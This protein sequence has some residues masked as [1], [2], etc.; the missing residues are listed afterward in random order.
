VTGTLTYAGK[1]VE[2]TGRGYHDHQWCNINPMVAWRHWL[3]GRMY[4]EQYTIYIYDFVASERFGFTPVPFFGVQDNHTSETIFHTDGN[5]T[6]ETQ[7]THDDQ[8]DRDFPKVS[9]Y[10]FANAD[11]ASVQFHI[12]WVQQLDTR[13]TY[14]MA[15]PETKKV[16]DALRL[17]PVYS[18]YF[19]KGSVTITGPD[20]QPVTENGQMIFEFPY[21]GNPDPE[22]TC[23][24]A[25][26]VRRIERSARAPN[27]SSSSSSNPGRSEDEHLQLLRSEVHIQPATPS[28]SSVLHVR[29]PRLC[30][31]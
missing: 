12:E 18:R 31:R 11:G 7:L 30:R 14:H 28:A 19:A 10:T 15:D 22:R 4:T 2:V 6:R 23:D 17:H 1:T 3:W 25:G 16:L 29:S 21:N 24:R 27:C 26:R 9:H 8:L 13:D 5:F 20:S